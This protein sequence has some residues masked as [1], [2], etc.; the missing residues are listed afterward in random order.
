MSRQKRARE[1]ESWGKLY[2]P[3]CGQPLTEATAHEFVGRPDDFAH[4]SSSCKPRLLAQLQEIRR[5]LDAKRSKPQNNERPDFKSIFMD[6]A[7]SLAR[8]STCRRLKVGC[9]IVRNDFRKVEAIGYNGGAAGQE[10]ECE[11]DEPGKCGHLHAEENA[12]ING[13]G[14]A[15]ETAKFLFTTNFPCPMCCK[16]IVNYGGIERVYYDNEYRDTGGIDILKRAKISIVDL[17]LHRFLNE[18]I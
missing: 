2:C 13:S 16:R 14:V 7:F 18:S 12:I 8:R 3:D 1:S 5:E 15:R 9:V 4:H 6:L 11:S 17:R 10:N